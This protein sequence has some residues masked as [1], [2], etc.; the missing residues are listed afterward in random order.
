MQFAY[1]NHVLGY[2]VQIVHR[3]IR[4]LLAPVRLSVFF[5]FPFWRRERDSA[6]RIGKA[7]A[8]RHRQLALTPSLN[9][10]FLA[11]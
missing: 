5:S 11:A 7:A 3:A 1:A 6:E 4:P 8:S 10:R 9:F 2:M